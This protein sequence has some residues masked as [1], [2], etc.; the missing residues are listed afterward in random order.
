M[1]SWILASFDQ[2]V[3]S[4]PFSFHCLIVFILGSGIS[5]SSFPRSV[6]ACSDN[7]GGGDVNQ[8]LMR[9]DADMEELTVELAIKGFD[10]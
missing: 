2:P 10:E 5:S 7:V 9:D 6:A 4:S 3:F 1:L 8:K